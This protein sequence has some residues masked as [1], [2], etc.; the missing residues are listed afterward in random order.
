M[1]L[2]RKEFEELV[3]RAL[4]ELP[5]DIAEALSN[6]S[7]V[8]EQW[9]SPEI[10]KEMNLRNRHELLGLYQGVP[11]SRRG[12]SYGGVLPDRITVFQGPI[13][14]TGRTKSE[15]RESVRSVVVHEIAHH[16]GISEER[17]RE[18]GY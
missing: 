3:A 6:I 7:V 11:L 1:K 2:G 10:I 12:T 8:V 5:D 4:D 18:L 13:E 17:I 16:I 14:S 15:L 9:P